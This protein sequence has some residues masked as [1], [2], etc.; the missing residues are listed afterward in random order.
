M[1][2]TMATDDA[3]DPNAGISPEQLERERQME[4]A[5]KAKNPELWKKNSEYLAY[6]NGV[7]EK[8]NDKDAKRA[9]EMMER[10]IEGEVTWA[11]VEGVPKK[12]LHEI[13]QSVY[14]QLKRG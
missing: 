8:I 12:V 3:F 4:E 11:E 2:P 1:E 14:L 6:I 13:A 7:L 10:F 5:E 9:V